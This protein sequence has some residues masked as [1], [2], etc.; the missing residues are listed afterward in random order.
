MCIQSAAKFYAA[1]MVLALEHL[2]GQGI[3]HR[4]YDCV[5]IH[6]PSRVLVDMNGP[7]I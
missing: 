5:H 6:M 1:E 3:I 4:Y 7:P 2:H